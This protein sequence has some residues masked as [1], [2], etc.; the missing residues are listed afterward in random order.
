[1]KTKLT[2]YR[3]TINDAMAVRSNLK[4]QIREKRQQSREIG[5]SLNSAH[6]ALD[7]LQIVS[8]ETQKQL[9]YKISELVSIAEKLVFSNPY[10][11]IVQY[12]SRY[13]RTEASL[14]FER[15]GKLY[16]PLSSTGYGTIDVAGFALRCSLWALR[17]PRFR[18]VILLDEPF[19]NINDPTRKL[20]ENAAEMIKEISE[21]L[22]IQFIIISRI[23][24]IQNISDRVFEVSKDKQDN[25]HI[26]RVK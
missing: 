16:H 23:P 15:N 2:K 5:K 11:L 17:S 21:R 9:E 22:N 4:L 19:K 24:E 8:I 14:L 3:K 13:N 26:E 7:I 10:N 20:Q 12:K 18:N 25:S 1:M 6:R